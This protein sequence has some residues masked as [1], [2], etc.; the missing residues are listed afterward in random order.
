MWW[1]IP[2]A[3]SIYRVIV[4]A[5]NS[6]E[7]EVYELKDRKTQSNLASLVSWR[8]RDS[9]SSPLLGFLKSLYVVG[10]GNAYSLCRFWLTSTKQWKQR[11][12]LGV[13]RANPHVSLACTIRREPFPYHHRTKNS[14]A[15]TGH[16]KCPASCWYPFYSCHRHWSK[17]A[18]INTKL[19]LTWCSS[20]T[21][22]SICGDFRLRGNH[23]K[24]KFNIWSMRAAKI[25][26]RNSCTPEA[27][28]G[29]P[30]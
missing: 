4:C 29:T 1:L 6:Q 18:W 10:N 8:Q 17:W 9:M 14:Q 25:M 26:E 16:R 24:W 30:P 3:L 28:S 23:G 22:M 12:G 21:H 20:I 7:P 27:F 2:S 15:L 19:G 13:Q 5:H 11:N